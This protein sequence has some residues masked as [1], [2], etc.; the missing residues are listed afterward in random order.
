MTERIR[1]G[2][3]CA[4]VVRS[5][6]VDADAL[7]ADFARSLAGKGWRVQGLIQ[8]LS[9][10]GAQCNRDIDLLDLSERARYRISQHLGRGSDACCIDPHGLAEAGGVLRRA[11]S[12][13]VDLAI[14][15]RFGK[16]EAEGGGLAGEFL[17]LIA[18][19]IP[20]L[21]VVTEKHLERWLEFTGG[22]S[23]LLAPEAAALDA[24]FESLHGHEPA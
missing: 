5:D 11:L 23:A 12:E 2:C 9:G 24:W 14:V 3:H 17:T 22:L 6:D 15:N 1:E 4:A 8:S 21:T 18:E 13:R 7:V 16:L 10:G 19:G 20:V